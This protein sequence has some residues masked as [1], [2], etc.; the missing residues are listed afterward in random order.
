MQKKFQFFCSLEIFY[1][2][3]ETNFFNVVFTSLVSKLQQRLFKM[4]HFNHKYGVTLMVS[5]FKPRIS[6][7]E[8]SCGDWYM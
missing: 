8:H 4:I 7:F 6:Q 3:L 2:I 5:Q 1:E